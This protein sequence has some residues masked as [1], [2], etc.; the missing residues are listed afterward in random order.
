MFTIGQLVGAVPDGV[1]RDDGLSSV[2]DQAVQIRIDEISND[3]IQVTVTALGGL[4]QSE[5]PRRSRFRARGEA[6][7]ETQP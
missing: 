7:V 1:K 2:G 6:Q 3:L 5:A 4:L